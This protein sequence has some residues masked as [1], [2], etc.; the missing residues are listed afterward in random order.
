MMNNT[1]EVD[2]HQANS[3]AVVNQIILKVAQQC[4]LNCTYCYVYNRGDESWK[5]RPRIISEQ[6]L[7]KL[8]ERINEHARR[9]ALRSFTIELHGGE[10]LLLG[11]RRMQ[12]LLDLLRSKVDSTKLRFTLQTNGLLLNTEWIDLL[13]RNEVTIGIS[14][15]GPPRHA[16]RFRVRR[17]GGGS[18]QALLDIIG[19]LRSEGDT[20][21]KVCSGYLCVVHPDMDGCELVDWFVDNGC[22]DFDFLLPQGNHI[23]PPQGWCGVSPYR[24][25][26]LSAFERWYSMGGRAPHIRKFGLP[27]EQ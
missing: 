13:A 14:L 19:R 12:A 9:H 8:A 2:N 4:N 16:D 26:L 20:F 17:N 3:N 25:F 27:L 23:N 10:P 7:N 6:V 21:E 15:D 11:K 1:P 5:T 22:K 24:E 18:T